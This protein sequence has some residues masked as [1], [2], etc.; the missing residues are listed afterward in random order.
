MAQKGKTEHIGNTTRTGKP[1]DFAASGIEGGKA[2]DYSKEDDDGR[3][4]TSGN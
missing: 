1:K 4:K 2:A 3:S